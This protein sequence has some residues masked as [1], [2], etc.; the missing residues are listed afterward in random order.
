M[1]QQ[2]TTQSATVICALL[3]TDA[4][5]AT[6]IAGSP[7]GWSHLW[8]VHV[9]EMSGPK[10]RTPAASRKET[11]S[12]FL[13]RPIHLERADH[14]VG[15]HGHEDSEQLDFPYRP[16]LKSRSANP[17]GGHID[18]AP[19]QLVPESDRRKRCQAPTGSGSYRL[20][21]RRK[22]CQAPTG[23]LRLV[24]LLVTCPASTR[25]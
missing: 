20:R 2:F 11:F 10:V 25:S 1:W 4:R 19:G 6:S 16:A 7:T 17:P 21:K 22:R 8:V 14:E 12:L 23:W 18:H 9:M 13:A 5:N 15:R 24:S 3:A